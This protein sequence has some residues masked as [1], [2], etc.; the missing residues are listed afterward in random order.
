[1]E[2]NIPLRNGTMKSRPSS[3]LSQEHCDFRTN[4]SQQKE[5]WIFLKISNCR[6]SDLLVQIDPFFRQILV[7]TAVVF[8]GPAMAGYFSSLEIIIFSCAVKN[9]LTENYHKI[10]ILNVIECLKSQSS[11]MMILTLCNKIYGVLMI[12]CR[13]IISWEL[14]SV[15]HLGALS[16]LHF[17]V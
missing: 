12:C 10:C 6:S 16:H 13:I 9:N 17:T 11:E 3:R 4:I 8:T 7:R 2:R 5:L 14:Q 1:M 15:R